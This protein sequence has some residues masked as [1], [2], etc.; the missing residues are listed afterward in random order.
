LMVDEDEGSFEGGRGSGG[1]P[2]G[3]LVS[4][5]RRRVDWGQHWSSHA[6]RT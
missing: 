5:A 2:A 4:S 3:E 1:C 6:I